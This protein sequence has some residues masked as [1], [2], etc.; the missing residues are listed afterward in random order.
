[1]IM[2]RSLLNKKNQ[3][4]T[5][6]LQIENGD[7]NSLFKGIAKK[8]DSVAQNVQELIE[9]KVDIEQLF[10]AN[11]PVQ[12]ILTSSVMS[13]DVLTVRWEDQVTN[14]RI[15]AE[16]AFNGASLYV[17]KISIPKDKN[18]TEYV[19]TLLS[20]DKYSFLKML[21]LVKIIKKLLRL[22]KSL[23]LTC[24]QWFKKKFGESVKK[25]WKTEVLMIKAI[26]TA[27]GVNYRFLLKD[28]V[29]KGIEISD[30]TLQ[31]QILSELDRNAVNR[32][33]YLL[34]YSENLELWVK[35]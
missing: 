34:I 4:L 18:L 25:C 5:K 21:S 8:D 33:Y 12:F 29:L 3:L 14:L 2:Q 28:N 16:L 26:D 19:N 32:R 1:M 6:L 15:E 10:R 30:Q 31:Q 35:I 7:K 17:T 11:V 13:G 23:R 9:Q 20:T 27:S 22:T 24:V